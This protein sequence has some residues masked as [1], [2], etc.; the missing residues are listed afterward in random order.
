LTLRYRAHIGASKEYIEKYISSLDIDRVL[1]RHVVYTMI[2]HTLSLTE[3]QVISG[4]IASQIIKELIDIAKTD[5]EKLYEWLEE[6]KV[7]FEDIFEALEAY[8]YEVLG[9]KAGYIAIGRSRNDHISMVLRLFARE[10]VLSILSELLNLRRVLIEK[11]VKYAKMIFPFYTHQQI[12]QCGSAALYFLSYEYVFRNAWRDV[13][14]T[15]EHLNENPLGSGPAAGSM[16]SHNREVLARTLCIKEEIIPPY[17]ATGSRYFLLHVVSALS[18]AL[19]EIGRLIEDFMLMLSAIPHAIEIPKEHIATSSIMPHK[20]NPVT[21]EISRSKIKKVLGLASSMFDIYESIPYG[22]NLDLQELN[23][24][25]VNVVTET[26]SILHVISDFLKGVEINE[27]AIMDYIKDKPCWSSDVVEYIAYT[28]NMPAREVYMNFSELFA[29][30][31]WR[32]SEALS[33]ILSAFNLTLTKIW[34]V[35]RS[36]PVESSV[37]SLIENALSNLKQDEETLRKI[38]E[39]LKSCYAKLESIDYHTNR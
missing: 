26:T 29:K 23:Q 16:V 14:S 35:V 33:N 34:E 19:V 4:D 20:R 18:L 31:G 17:Y 22:Y 30:Y 3:N 1:A 10:V 9:E 15:L 13:L 36:K 5:G 27:Q 38:S 39:F 8:L 21:L 11:A 12:A 32:S 28:R 25:F 2:A 24:I 6:K 7:V 37:K